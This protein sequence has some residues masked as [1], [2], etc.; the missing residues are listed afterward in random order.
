M[1]VLWRVHMCAAGD[2]GAACLGACAVAARRARVLRGEAEEPAR[3]LGAGGDLPLPWW[4]WVPHGGCPAVVPQLARRAAER[5]VAGRGR[6]LWAPAGRR[7][8]AT[9]AVPRGRR[10][11]GTAPLP[12]GL[13]L[14]CSPAQRGAGG[15]SRWVWGQ[16]GGLGR[17]RQLN[18]SS[19]HRLPA[20]RAPL[21]VRARVCLHTCVTR[22]KSCV[23]GLGGTGGDLAARQTW[24]RVSQP[25]S[26]GG[27]P[28]LGQGAEGLIPSFAAGPSSSGQVRSPP[29]AKP[30]PFPAHPSFPELPPVPPPARVPPSPLAV[31]AAPPA[32]HSSG[33]TGSQSPGTR[34]QRGSSCGRIAAARTPSDLPAHPPTS[35]PALSQPG[36]GLPGPLSPRSRKGGG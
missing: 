29:S 4:R 10:V 32:L 30:A 23:Q 18:R 13:G 25:L 3:G 28:W 26:W 2:T 5:H 16:L 27:V 14:P 19:A 1:R 36:E 20:A 12:V 8:E 33:L 35:P 7:A 6:G 11:C 21:Q 9:V 15:P 34:F 31:P 22:V 17:G 24:G